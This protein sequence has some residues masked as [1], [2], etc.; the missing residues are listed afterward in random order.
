[1]AWLHARSIPFILDVKGWPVVE[2]DTYI[3]AFRTSAPKPASPNRK[4]LERLQQRT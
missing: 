3:A 1:M 4:A 2:H